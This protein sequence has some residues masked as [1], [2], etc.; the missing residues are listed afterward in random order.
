MDKITLELTPAEALVV[1]ARMTDAAAEGTR[2]ASIMASGSLELE[3]V[4]QAAQIASRV[5]LRI[6]NAL[7]PRC[8][9]LWDD[10]ECD[11]APVDGERYCQFHLD[12]ME[13]KFPSFAA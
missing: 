4:Q 1:H 13:H 2:L 8:D 7:Y 11:R 3:V 9:Y 12:R 6:G 5:A 10:P